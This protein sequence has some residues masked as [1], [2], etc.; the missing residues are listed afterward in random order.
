M[1]KA[2]TENVKNALAQKAKKT[3]EAKLNPTQI[4]RNQ[5]EKMLPEF[6]KVISKTMSPERFTRI[7]LTLFNSDERFREVEPKSF[8]SALMQ[9]A[10]VGLE[11]NTALGEAYI[12][13]YM[14]HQTKKM[15][16]NYQLSY[17]GLLKLAYNS[18][19][20]ET[21]YAHEVHEGDKFEYAYGLEKKLIHVPS[22]IPS[23]VITHYYA[24]YKL[25][26]GG[27]DF[28]VWSKARVEQ[29][30]KNFSRNY[31]FQGSVNEKSVW[32]KHFDSMAK[33]TAIIDVLKYAPKSVELAAALNLDYK[34]NTVEEKISDFNIID[35]DGFTGD[36]E[37]ID[38]SFNDV[39]DD[40]EFN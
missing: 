11:P 22:D 40:S 7:A 31:F 33:K 10:Q 37:S 25:K 19:E 20:Y 12:I 18:N 3:E 2:N 5:L 8:L 26:N 14:N 9:C 29:H 17:K 32:F 21:I 30:A 28:V 15:E 1:V 16:I 34:E 36:N 35:V 13:P 39:Q 4:M 38:V 27:S 23:N 24:V 6:G